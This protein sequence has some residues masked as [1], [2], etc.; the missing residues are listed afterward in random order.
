MP[1]RE[2]ARNSWRLCVW[3][4]GS[5]MW[6]GVADAQQSGPLDPGADAMNRFV[7]PRW[8]MI[9]PPKDF[10]GGCVIGFYAFQF[11]STGYF[12]FNNHVRGSWRVDEIG[13]LRLRTRD[14][15]TFILIVEG[16]IIRPAR[17]LPFAKRTWQF[18]R[19]AT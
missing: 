3:L 14:G 9:R 5:L 15:L 11:S 1:P 4:F 6:M 7:G 8:S 10:D 19:C 16:N 18:Q 17:N 2:R 13:N 12:V